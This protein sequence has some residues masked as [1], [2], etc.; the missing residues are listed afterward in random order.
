[1]QV[2]ANAVTD[3]SQWVYW[4]VTW[5]VQMLAPTVAAIVAYLQH[6]AARRERQ[7]IEGRYWRYEERLSDLERSRGEWSVSA[8]EYGPQSG[9]HKA[10]KRWA[11]GSKH[12][13][14]RGV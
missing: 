10:Y 13:K 1:M 5:A 11:K 14:S 2:A 12:D 4:C 8:M 7:R 9:G 3:N 6:R